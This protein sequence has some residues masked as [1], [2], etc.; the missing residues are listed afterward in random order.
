MPSESAPPQIVCRRRRPARWRCEGFSRLLRR[1]CKSSPRPAHPTRVLG[2][3]LPRGVLGRLRRVANKT[4]ER[5]QQAGVTGSGR[6]RRMRSNREPPPRQV[7][8]A[9]SGTCFF[10]SEAVACSRTNQMP[11]VP[12]AELSS[13]PASA[14]PGSDPVVSR[15]AAMLQM[16]EPAHRICSPV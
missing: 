12:A 11:A 5:A 15:P 14:V 2:R 6:R 13:H 7:A 9:G 1:Q 8:V 10:S 16:K 3:R 4:L